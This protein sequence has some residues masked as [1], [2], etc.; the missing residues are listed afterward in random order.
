M[1]KINKYSSDIEDSIMANFNTKMKQ[2]E[3]KDLAQE[4]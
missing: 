3:S 2:K 1:F 4:K